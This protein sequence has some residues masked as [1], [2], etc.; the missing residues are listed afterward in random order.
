MVE[1]EEIGE[2]EFTPSQNE[3]NAIVMPNDQI[4]ALF[5][6]L[7]FTSSWAILVSE[8]KVKHLEKVE[9]LVFSFRLTRFEQ[10][11]KGAAIFT[12]YF[13]GYDF[14]LKVKV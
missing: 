3:I 1:D 11:F 14:N 9:S 10:E 7:L 5:N 2:Q 6:P 4:T 13:S 8:N 12:L